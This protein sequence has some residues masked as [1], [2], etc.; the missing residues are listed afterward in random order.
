MSGECVLALALG[1]PIT[2]ERYGTWYYVE[3]RL[4]EDLKEVG[5]IF[6]YLAR[7]GEERYFRAEFERQEKLRATRAA[8]HAGKAG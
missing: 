4:L 2:D 1:V 7:R 5:L 8:R 6:P 3:T